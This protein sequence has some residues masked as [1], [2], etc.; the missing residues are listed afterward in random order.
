MIFF[1]HQ[2]RS[3]FFVKS[4]FFKNSPKKRKKEAAA[5]GPVPTVCECLSLVLLDVDKKLS[6]KG[7]PRV[8]ERLDDRQSL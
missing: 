5:A 7:L 1:C 8:K 6:W 2:Q 4:F 3:F